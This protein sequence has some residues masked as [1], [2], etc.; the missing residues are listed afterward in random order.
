M[1]HLLF[2]EYSVEVKE[3]ENLPGN[4]KKER[5]KQL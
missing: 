1:I 4:L 5:V 3:F 2:Q